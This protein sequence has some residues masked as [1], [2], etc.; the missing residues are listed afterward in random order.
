V[1]ARL[2]RLLGLLTSAR[3]RRVQQGFQE[4]K[5]RLQ[6]IVLSLAAPRVLAHHFIAD[7]HQA[8]QAAQAQDLA[9]LR[10]HLAAALQHWKGACAQ[11]KSFREELD[12]RRE[13]CDLFLRW[14]GSGQISAF[15]LTEH[16][17]GSDTARVATRAQLRSVSV[18][19]GE[20]GVLKFVPAG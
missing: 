18:E 2:E 8:E 1:Q 17:A 13:A 20:K 15:A 12:R 9:A 3:A 5:H 19:R 4:L 14:I 6:Q 10:E 11:A 16:S 7:W